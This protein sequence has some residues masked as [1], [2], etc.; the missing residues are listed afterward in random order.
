MSTPPG[1]YYTAERWNNWL[2]RLREEEID[3]ESDDSARLFFNLLDDATIAIAKVITD[4][5]DGE[6]EDAEAAAAE[7]DNIRAIVL[8]EVDIDDEEKL[9]LV[10]GIQTSLVCALYAAEEYIVGGPAE[11]GTI[12]Q[13]IDAAAAAEAEEEDLDTALAHCV[14]AGTL[15]IEGDDIGLDVAE[16]IEYG[17]VADWVN[18]LDSLG[19]A[20]SDPELVEEE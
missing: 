2:D 7:I 15:V 1:E 3:P 19:R 17:F 20:L 16:D 10:D 12:E 18:G 13:Y 14:Q 6:F 5:E 4:Y 8:E 11:E 9:T